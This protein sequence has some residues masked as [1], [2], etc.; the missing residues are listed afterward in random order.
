MAT[1]KAATVTTKTATND[2]AQIATNTYSPTCLHAD[3]QTQT[4]TH[5]QTH[6]HTC[7]RSIVRGMAMHNNA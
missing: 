5:K 4:Q 3:T 2:E 7:I 6:T 1:D